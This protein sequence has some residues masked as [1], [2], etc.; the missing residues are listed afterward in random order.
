MALV[1]IITCTITNQFYIGSTDNLSARCHR[2]VKDLINRRHHCL[3][4]QQCFDKYGMLVW[5]T[6]SITSDRL[7][8]DQAYQA[9]D[10]L[11]QANAN[12]PLMLNTSLN[13]RFGNTLS[14]HPNKADI[15]HKRSE[16]HSKLT[17][18]QRRAS[19]ARYGDTNPNWK[20]G[21]SYRFYKPCS[22]CG[23]P[24]LHE[25]CFRCKAKLRI[26]EKNSFYGKRH[27]A[28]TKTKLSAAHKGKRSLSY[29]KKVKIDNVIYDAIA[30]A[31]R[32]LGKHVTVISYRC[33]SKSFPN[34]E[35]LSTN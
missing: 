25:L 11:I 21:I 33:K 2:H 30:D 32:A 23:E 4:M 6:E 31:A 35:I 17:P 14:N 24:C 22:N 13:S 19:Y 3:R 29:C 1:Y 27:T 12:N 28:E 10:Q 8:R 15:I 20:G 7:S 5:R 16:T 26:G 9:E 18:E 34:Y